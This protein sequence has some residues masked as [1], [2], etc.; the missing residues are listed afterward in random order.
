MVGNRAGGP[1]ICG[2]PKVNYLYKPL[3]TQCSWERGAQQTRF[4][5]ETQNL[6]N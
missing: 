5:S 1:A 3:I 2:S 6:F 4:V